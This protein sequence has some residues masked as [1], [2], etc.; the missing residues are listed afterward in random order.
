MNEEVWKDIPGYEG[1]YQVSNLGRVKSLSR[2]IHGANQS[3]AY[4][5]VSKERILRPGRHDK[6]GH[7]SVML[8]S[9]RRCCLVHQLVLRAFIGE[10]SDGTVVLHKNGDSADNRLE[11]LRYD[12]QSENV[13]DVY[14]QGKAWKKLTADDVESIRFGLACGMSCRELGSMYDVGHQA[15]SKIKN[16]ERYQWLK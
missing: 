2:I 1:K 9:P 7:L 14:R 4:T 11:N 3:S 15:I 6:S 8:N 16:R 10:S 5:W 12:T 13:H